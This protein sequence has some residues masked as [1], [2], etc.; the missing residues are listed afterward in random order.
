MIN[1]FLRSSIME[2][3]VTI[4]PVTWGGGGIMTKVTVTYG[5]LTFGICA[6]T[7]FLNGPKPMHYKYY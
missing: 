1:Y 2:K 3:V 4:C 5:G 7:P 6:M